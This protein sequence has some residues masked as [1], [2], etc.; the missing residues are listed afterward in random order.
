MGVKEVSISE[1]R[2]SS[3]IKTKGEENI[4]KARLETFLQTPKVKLSF[5]VTTVT[6]T[7]L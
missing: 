2:R 5:N 6:G 1:S 4:K 3:E 7:A